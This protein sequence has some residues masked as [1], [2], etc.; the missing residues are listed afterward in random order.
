MA[1]A[2]LT[3]Y[4]G[5]PIFRGCC[6]FSAENCPLD[7]FPSATN[8]QAPFGVYLSLSN[9]SYLPSMTMITSEVIGVSISGGIWIDSPLRMAITLAP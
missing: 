1:C 7:S 5:F 8:P 6:P 4:G 9:I 3:F 2:V